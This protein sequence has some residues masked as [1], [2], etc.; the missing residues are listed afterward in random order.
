GVNIIT[1]MNGGYAFA[2]SSTS[3]DGDISG[4]NNGNPN[5]SKADYWIVELDSAGNILWENN[6]G[7]YYDDDPKSIAQTSDGGFIVTG[8]STSEDGDV[9]GHHGNDYISSDCWVIKVDSSGNKLWE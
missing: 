8:F 7:G 2:S 6:F 5:A 9:S 4:N 3:S 1:T